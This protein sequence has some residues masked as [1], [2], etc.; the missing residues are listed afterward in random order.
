MISE[1]GQ[2]TQDYLIGVS[3]FLVTVTFVFGYLPTVFDSYNAPVD[4]IDHAQADRAAEFLVSNYTVEG[5]T[6]VLRHQHFNL[7]S[8]VRYEVYD[9]IDRLPGSY[10]APD[11]TGTV[12]KFD[13]IDPGAND[14]VLRFRGYI[15]VP[16]DGSYEFETES[17]DGSRLSIDGDVVVSNLHVSPSSPGS[18]TEGGTVQLSEGNHSIT[19][20]YYD[21]EDPSGSTALEVRWSGPS[22]GMTEIQPEE[23]HQPGRGIHEML[24]NVSYRHGFLAFRQDTGLNTLTDRQAKPNVNVIIANSSEIRSRGDTDPI[25]APSGV[26]YEYGDD[27]DADVATASETRVIQLENDTYNYCDPTCWLVVRVW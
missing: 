12:D 8:G 7:S 6:N 26:A 19:V 11:E 1:R 15:E 21:D 17:D 25:I 22:F 16:A 24:R 9:G 2:T 10:G 13:L 14:Y 3:I 27:P 20:E 4:G 5:R 23:L 18:Q